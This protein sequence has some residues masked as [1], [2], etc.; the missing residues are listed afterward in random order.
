MFSTREVGEV[1]P[2]YT[3]I[4]D[5]QVDPESASAD[6]KDMTSVPNDEVNL[7]GDETSPDISGIY[8]CMSYSSCIIFILINV[9][10]YQQCSNVLSIG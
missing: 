4:E 2:D 10:T 8:V 7:I 1:D 5:G 9:C 3:S 6:N